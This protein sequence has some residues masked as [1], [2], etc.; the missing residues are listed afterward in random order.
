MLY[1]EIMNPNQV[2]SEVKSKLAQAT[3]H[4]R[5]ELKKIR[6]GRAHPAMLD[7]ITV[8]VYGQAMPLKGVAGIMAPEAQLLQVSPFDP[9]NLQAISE[10]IRNNQ[11][12]FNPADD[13]RIIRIQVPPL[14]EETRVAMVKVLNQKVEET[15][16]TARQIRHDAMRRGELAEKDKEI[17]RD[18]RQRFEKQI[19]ELLTSQKTEIESLA[20]AKEQEILTI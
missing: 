6:T 14:T 5:E 17:G 9:A 2:L 13:G 7:G 10:A 4:F 16:I 1:N 12:G 8:E 15:F 18:E 20:K 19:D 11:M 3:D